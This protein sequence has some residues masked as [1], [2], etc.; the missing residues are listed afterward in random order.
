MQVVAKISV[1][2]KTSNRCD[3]HLA[4]VPSQDMFRWCGR[5]FVAQWGGDG[6][7]A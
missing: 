2:V 3:A 1:S 5:F 7:V 6:G 4:T